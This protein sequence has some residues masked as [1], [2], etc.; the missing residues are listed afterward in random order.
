LHD[1]IFRDVILIVVIHKTVARRRQ[2]SQQRNEREQ[3]ANETRTG[4]GFLLRDFFS[5]G[6][7]GEF[8]VVMAGRKF[9]GTQVFKTRVRMTRFPNEWM[10]DPSP[11]RGKLPAATRLLTFRQFPQGALVRIGGTAGGFGKVA[12][13]AE[14]RPYRSSCAGFGEIEGLL[15]GLLRMSKRPSS[16]QAMPSASSMAG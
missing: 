12:I 6:K 5:P 16:A 9:P 13:A 10:P 3:Q 4:H 11:W 2:I 7:R 1:G 15:R 14:R 8:S